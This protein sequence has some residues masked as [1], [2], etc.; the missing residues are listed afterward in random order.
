MTEYIPDKWVVVKIGGSDPHYRVLG[1]WSGGYVNGDSWRMNSGI[2]KVDSDDNYWYFYGDSGSVYKCRISSY[3]FNLMSAQ[4]YE[5][6]KEMYGD[7]FEAL[8][9]Q[10]WTTEDW[11]WIIK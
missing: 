6:Y 5:R 2:T 1:G 11:D 9:D 10:E 4:I 7:D 3:G 8:D